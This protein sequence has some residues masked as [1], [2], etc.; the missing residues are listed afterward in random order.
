MDNGAV[1]PVLLEL[2]GYERSFTMKKLVSLKN[3]I[4]TEFIVAD[5]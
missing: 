1:A 4:K 5:A 2:T 3:K